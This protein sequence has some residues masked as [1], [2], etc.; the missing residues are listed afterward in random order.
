MIYVHFFG[1]VTVTV[2]MSFVAQPCIP[3]CEHIQAVYAIGF[4]EAAIPN[5]QIRE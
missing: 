4:V 2:G 1:F 3:E 5:L